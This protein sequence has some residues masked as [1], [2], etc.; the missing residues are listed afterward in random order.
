MKTH[1]NFSYHIP[2]LLSLTIVKQLEENFQEKIYIK[3]YELK[4]Y[5]ELIEFLNKSKNPIEGHYMERLW[6]YMFTKNKPIF[7]SIFDVIYTKVERSRFIY[8]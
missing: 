4:F 1:Q 7:E 5:K 2:L 6:R 8:I 3:K